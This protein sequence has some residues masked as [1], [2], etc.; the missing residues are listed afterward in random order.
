[1]PRLSALER[2]LKITE[3]AAAALA[4][5]DTSGEDKEALRVR[6]GFEYALGPLFLNSSASPEKVA[7]RLALRCFK[8]FG[9][10]FALRLA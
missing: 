1:M 7:R 3:M 8:K 2:H 5:R 4:P 9:R 6:V 10:R